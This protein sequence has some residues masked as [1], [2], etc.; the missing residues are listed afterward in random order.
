MEIK[1]KMTRKE[2]QELLGKAF[3]ATMPPGMRVTSVEWNPY[4]SHVEIDATDEPDELETTANAV[5]A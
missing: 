4:R 1:V 3:G 5:A 2:A